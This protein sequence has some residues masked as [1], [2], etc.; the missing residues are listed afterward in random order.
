MS[1]MQIWPLRLG[2]REMEASLYSWSFTGW[3]KLTASK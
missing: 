2:Q 1:A 3:G